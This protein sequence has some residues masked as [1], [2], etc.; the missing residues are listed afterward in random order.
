[1]MKRTRAYTCRRFNTSRMRSYE[2][3]TFLNFGI[4]RRIHALIC[5]VSVSVR[6]CDVRCLRP[7][8]C[9]VIINARLV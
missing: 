8:G 4:V 9:L 2:Y 7:Y 6:W 3:Y 1:M 5:V